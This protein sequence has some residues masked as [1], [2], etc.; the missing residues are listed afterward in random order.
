MESSE[1]LMLRGTLA[2]CP[3]CD[4]ERAL[5][6]TDGGDAF[7]CTSCDAAVFVSDVPLALPGGTRLRTP[8]AG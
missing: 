1:V 2:W 3:D 6:P 5:V 7:C 8:L 4:D